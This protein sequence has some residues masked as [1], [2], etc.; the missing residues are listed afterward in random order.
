MN[1]RSNPAAANAVLF[2]SVGADRTDSEKRAFRK[3]V[4]KRRAKKG[5]R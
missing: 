1:P 4:A 3:R 5:Y 2:Q